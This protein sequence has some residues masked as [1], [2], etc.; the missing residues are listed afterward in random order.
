MITKELAYRIEQEGVN[1]VI[2]D[3]EGDEVKVFSNGMVDIGE[4]V[5]MFTEDELEEIGI[6]E[7]SALKCS[8]K[9]L[10][11]A[12]TTKICFWK[13]WRRAATT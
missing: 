3:N 13:N 8:A 9:S 4:Y 10:T 1:V 11:N 5:P 2:L 6:N 7:R 12:A